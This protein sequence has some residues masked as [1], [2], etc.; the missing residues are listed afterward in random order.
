M[1]IKSDIIRWTFL[2]ELIKKADE[3]GGKATGLLFG[4]NSY[5][6]TV[7]KREKE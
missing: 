1:T 7:E 2:T 4:P 6:V 3:Q 5:V